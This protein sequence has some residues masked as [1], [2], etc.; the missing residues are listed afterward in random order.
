MARFSQGFRTTGTGSA[1]PAL[2]LIGGAG[3]KARLVEFGLTVVTQVVAAVGIG[4]PAA[5]GL[6]PTTPVTFLSE[7]QDSSTIAITSA[8]AWG[9]PPTSPTYFY[10]RV[11]IPLGQDEIVWTWP[12]GMGIMLLPATSIVLWLFATAPQFDGWAV[13]EQ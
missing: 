8:L 7:A 13:F 2:E 4:Y 3:V 1:S 11:S 5:I 9:T 12:T 6:I 10:R